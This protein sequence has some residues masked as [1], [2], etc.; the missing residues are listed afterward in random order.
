MARTYDLLELWAPITVGKR[1]LEVGGK[2]GVYFSYHSLVVVHD[3]IVASRVTG[4]VVIGGLGNIEDAA[5]KP[6]FV[7]E[8]EGATR[9]GY[10]F[11]L[12]DQGTI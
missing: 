12:S 10:E 2:S 3:G 6:K 7:H 5:I 4:H 1:F 8:R 9:P 11:V